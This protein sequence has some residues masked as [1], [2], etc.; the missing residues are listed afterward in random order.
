MRGVMSVLPAAILFASATLA[1]AA[2]IHQYRL[3]GSLADDL[4]GPSLVADG[5][6]LNATDYSFA[7]NQGLSLSNALPNAGNYS[8]EFEFEFDTL[9]GYRKLVDFKD[10]TADAGLYNLNTAL[11]FFPVT[12]GSSGA[13]TANVFARLVLTRDGSSNAVTGYVNGVQ[14]I[15]FTDSGSLAV[16]SAAN[17]IIRFFED[18]TKTGP[19]EASAGAVDYIRIYDAPLTAA[20]VAA[21]TDPVPLGA[22]VPEPSSLALLSIGGMGLAWSAIRRRR[23]QLR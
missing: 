7:A 4:G 17:N 20:D 22:V 15:T 13:F 18:D 9:S 2:L 14:Q 16:F 8:I 1:E 3:D 10:L 19:S 11:N 23:S 21:L 12:G 5:G 6:T